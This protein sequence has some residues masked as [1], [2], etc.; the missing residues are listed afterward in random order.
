MI[1]PSMT[2]EEIVKAFRKDIEASENKIDSFV[3]NFASL[4]L[5]RSRNAFPFSKTY[6]YVTWQKN[7]L[8]ITIIAT[9]RSDWK[10]PQFSIAGAFHTD[11]G[12][13]GIY[14]GVLSTGNT[15]MKGSYIFLPHFFK[16]YRERVLQDDTLTSK[17]VLKTFFSRNLSITAVEMSESFSKTYQKYEKDGVPQYAGKMKDGN[18]FMEHI[19][20][21]IC[22]V[23]TIITDDMLYESQED[24]FG[25]LENLRQ[26]FGRMDKDFNLSAN[27]VDNSLPDF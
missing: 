5:K 6:E 16:R 14:L 23:K 7:L 13:H 18:C 27:P 8:F 26:K 11:E 3:S 9:K 12:I 2:Y 20:P 4:T 21:S 15:L 10:D 24:V 19:T 17:E 1:V 22:V 25:Q